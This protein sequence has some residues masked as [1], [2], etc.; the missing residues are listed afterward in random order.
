MFETKLFFKIWVVVSLFFLSC[1]LNAQN[2]EFEKLKGSWV[3]VT[4]YGNV[5]LSFN[6]DSQLAFDGEVAGY[7]LAGNVINVHNEY[8]DI[9][10]PYRF[11]EE[12]LIVDFPEGY[13]ML[14]NKVNQNNQN[15]QVQSQNESTT[16]SGGAN[17]LYGR[18]CYWS[19]SSNYYSSDDYSSYSSTEWVYFDGQGNFSYGSESSFSNNAGL[20]YGD[21][22]NPSQLGTYNIQGNQVILRF[23]D[24]SV[25]NLNINMRQDNG[26]ITELM[27]GKKLY[28]TSLC[29]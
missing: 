29:N 22:S 28:A 20:G 24:G 27:Y 17:N 26:Q 6:S 1:F 3:C 19:G 2:S 4:Q 16:G 23:N 21:N 7:S 14:F 8:G 15:N 11:Q 13:S 10:Y 18:L 25:V 5:N 12:Y 9:A